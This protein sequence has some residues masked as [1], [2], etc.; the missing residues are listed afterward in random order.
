MSLK[1]KS[2]ACTGSFSFL[3]VLYVCIHNSFFENVNVGSINKNLLEL[4]DLVIIKIM[5]IYYNLY[6]NF[7]K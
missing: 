7:I 5:F 3:P 1:Y 4:I 2:F 6:D